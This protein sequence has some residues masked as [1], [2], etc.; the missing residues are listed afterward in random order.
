MKV[1]FKKL[2]PEVP[3]PRYATAGSAGA[4]L[5]SAVGCLL[6]PG[7]VLIIPTGIAVEIPPGYEGQVRLRSSIGKRGFVMPNAPGTIDSDYRGEI[8]VSMINTRDEPQGIN[9]G[10]RIGQI[11]IA[12]ALQV[13]WEMTEEL[14]ATSRGNGG[15]GSTGT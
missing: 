9:F 14:S 15:F 10:E 3:S 4:D 11:I 8:H 13:K 1:K 6:M 7:E 12:P 2:N 5:S